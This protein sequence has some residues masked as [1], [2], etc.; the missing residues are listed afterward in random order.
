[1]TKLVGQTSLRK[2]T[3]QSSSMGC[4]NS[5]KN[6]QGFGE[7]SALPLLVRIMITLLFVLAVNLKWV[8]VTM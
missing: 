1:M 3:D 5:R 6:S 8:M 4:P 7:V 2:N